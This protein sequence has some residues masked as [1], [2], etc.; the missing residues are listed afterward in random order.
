VDTG[1]I[2][3]AEA[4]GTPTVDIVGPVDEREQP[5]IGQKHRVVV[6]PERRIPALHIMNAHGY[7]RKEARRQ[8]EAI[9]TA[10]V[11]DACREL[12]GNES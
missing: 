2:Y 6:P 8:S 9:T 1:P 11:L 10:M 3:V 5:P 7:D 4:F 12:L